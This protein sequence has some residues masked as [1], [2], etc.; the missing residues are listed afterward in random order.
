VKIPSENVRPGEG[1]TIKV[2]LSEGATFELTLVK[3]GR[4]LMGS[5]ADN[6]GSDEKPAHEIRF[7]V[8]FYIGTFPVTQAQWAA[9]F[10]DHNPSRFPGPERPVEMVSWHDIVDG[11]QD[12][13]PPEAFLTRINRQL[14]NYPKWTGYAFRLPTEAEW[15]YA[16]KGGHLAPQDFDQNTATKD[17]YPEYAGSDELNS[18]GWFEEA[19]TP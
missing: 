8:P 9:I 11:S 10:P 7:E 18:V 13:G 1:P 17:L 2:E 3:P 6:A 19:L 15:E 12:G 4:F 16:A 5:N 14:K